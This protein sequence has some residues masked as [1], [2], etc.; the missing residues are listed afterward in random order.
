MQFAGRY[1]F[2]IHTEVTLVLPGSMQEN[3]ADVDVEVP[4]HEL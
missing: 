3:C 1:E 2:G 4:V